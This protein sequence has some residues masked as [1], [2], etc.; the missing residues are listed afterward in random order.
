MG[1]VPHCDMGSD[2][3]GV[4]AELGDD[5]LLLDHLDLLV[6]GL[7]VDEVELVDVLEEDPDGGQGG[8]VEVLHEV[9]HADLGVAVEGLEGDRAEVGELVVD[10][11]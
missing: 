1:V 5:E 10:V 6:E 11:P 7:Q 3:R 2:D 8:P 9:A 4:L